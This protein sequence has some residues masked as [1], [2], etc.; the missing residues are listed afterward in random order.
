MKLLFDQNL[1]PRLVYRLTDLFP[2][3]NHVV[4][5]GLDSSDDIEVWRYARDNGFLLVTKDADFSDFSTLLGFP[6]KV[7]WIRLGNC[8]TSQIENL[9]RSHYDAIQTLN[10]SD[11]LGILSLL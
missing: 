3:S 8:T 9:L 5:L 6:P 4:A 10:E 11:S 7:I 1:S 2:D